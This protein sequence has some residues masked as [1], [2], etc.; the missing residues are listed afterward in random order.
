MKIAVIALQGAISEHVVFLR[1]VL[2]K[3][4]INCKVIYARKNEDLIDVNGIIIPGGES[5]TIGRLLKITEIDKTIV[6]LAKAGIPIMGTCTGCILLAKKC[7]VDKKIAQEPLLA[8]MDIE[9]VRNA[10]GRQYDSFETT[11]ILSSL[12]NEKFPGIF[13]RAPLIKKVFGNAKVFAKCNDQIVGAI[14][15]RMLAL[16]FHPELTNNY[17]IHELFIEMVRKSF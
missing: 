13:I 2:K 3:N 7:Y 11:V 4:R 10:Y 8:L 16:T 15:K 6:R 12:K 1:A 14:Q 9:V 17:R 5:T